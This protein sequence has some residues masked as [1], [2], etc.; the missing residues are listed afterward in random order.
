M[1][2]YSSIAQA[3]QLSSSVNNLVTSVAVS[4]LVGFPVSEPFTIVVDPSTVYEEI[5]TVTVVSGMTLTVT[6]GE[7]S[8]TAV[9][10]TAGAAVR[11]IMSARDLREPQEHIAATGN[12]HGVGV[13]SSIVGTATAQALTNKTIDGAAN[14]VTLP[15]S[16]ITSDVLAAARIPA[17]TDALMGGVELA[18]PAE[19]VTGTDD[20]RATTP[21]GV[22][23]A[24][25]DD[26]R[27]WLA[28]DTAPATQTDY[29]TLAIVASVTVTCV[30][31][32]KYFVTGEFEGVQQTSTGVIN[33]HFAGT[34]GVPTKHLY[35]QAATSGTTV[36]GSTTAIYEPT[37]TATRAFQVI[38]SDSAGALRIAALGAS[39]TVTDIGSA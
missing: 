15:A 25:A 17:A 13:G 7:D 33:V 37:A 12:I 1:R 38:A 28:T 24:I 20:Q 35:F 31:G 5:M 34:S 6:R 19:T 3:A 18:T 21:A 2:Y 29:S 27:G 16:A 23:A 4:S 26:P 10:H 30:A 36:Y 14:T 22:A 9:A 11:H 8:S 32:R 39:I